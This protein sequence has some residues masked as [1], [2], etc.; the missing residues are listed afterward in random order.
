MPPNSPGPSR[1]P[2]RIT[3]RYPRL[4][5]SVSVPAESLQQGAPKRTRAR[6]SPLVSRRRGP[7]SGLFLVHRR[8]ITRVQGLTEEEHDRNRLHHVRGLPRQVQRILDDDVTLG[9]IESRRREAARLALF[10]SRDVRILAIR[11]EHQLDGVRSGEGLGVSDRVVQSGLHHRALLDALSRSGRDRPE[12][13]TSPGPQHPALAGGQGRSRTPRRTPGRPGRSSI[14]TSLRSPLRRQEAGS[15]TTYGPILRSHL[16]FAGYAD[17]RR[18]RQGG[19]ARH[20][21]TPSPRTR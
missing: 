7:S 18:L 12:A 4:P 2:S 6:S 19:L 13:R 14:E 20:R 1:T 17:C 16:P 9:L 21:L 15:P 8:V 5:G 10:R 3:S 11:L